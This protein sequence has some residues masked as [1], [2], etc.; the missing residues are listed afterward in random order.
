MIAAEHRVLLSLDA[1]DG[2][3]NTAEVPYDSVPA[4]SHRGC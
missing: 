4:R 1:T 2:T 3:T